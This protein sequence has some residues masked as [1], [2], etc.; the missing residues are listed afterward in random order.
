[1]YITQL[2]NTISSTQ[3]AYCCNCNRGSPPIDSTS[4]SNCQGIVQRSFKK[5]PDEW[6]K[7]EVVKLRSIIKKQ[8]KNIMM[9]QLQ[10]SNGSLRKQEVF[11]QK[12]LS[13]KNKRQPRSYLHYKTTH[14]KNMYSKYPV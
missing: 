5:F 11:V 1:M 3:V 10:K 13:K 6:R 4:P 12:P 14:L 7:D 8:S 2:K 9:C